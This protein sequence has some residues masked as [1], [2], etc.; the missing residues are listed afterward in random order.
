[1][2]SVT[3]LLHALPERFGERPALVEL[4]WSESSYRRE[5]LVSYAELSDA[6]WRFADALARHGLRPGDRVAVLLDNSAEMVAT[7][8]ACLL[9]GCLWVA[10]NAR[11]SPEEHR[12]I[13]ED[14]APAALV[15]SR[16]HR[17]ALP[18]GIAGASRLFVEV[19]PRGQEQG[20]GESLQC[21]SGLE[22]ERAGAAL[23][24]TDLLGGSEARL[25]FDLPGAEDPVRIRYTSGTAGRPKGAVLPRRCYDA[26]VEVVGELIGPLDPTDVL[27]QVAPMTHAAG[28]MWLPHAA[29]GATALLADRF[30]A[31]AFADL[32]Q[33]ERVTAAFLVPTMLLRFLERILDAAPLASLRTIV[34]GGASM[35]ADRLRSGLERLGPV[36]VQI[37]GMTESNWP[38]TALRRE[39]HVVRGSAEKVR[40]RLASCGRPT[41]IGRVRLVDGAG[42]DVARG[43]VGELLLRGR[44]TMSGYW[45]GL[46]NGIERASR[47]RVEAGEGLDAEGNGI[48]L[49]GKG[50]DAEGW[51]HSGD[52]AFEDGDGFLTIVDR[53]HDMIVSGGFNVY[54][55]EL[56]DALSTHPAVLESAVVG[57]PD[58]EWGETVHAVVVL[59]AGAQA[60]AADLAAHVAA[61]TA[62]YKKPRS[63]EFVEELPKNAAG[64]VLRRALREATGPRGSSDMA[65]GPERVA[66]SESPKS[67]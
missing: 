17:G 48:E 46:A 24:W 30:D 20:A 56:E 21:N 35:P 9:T 51:M 65:G 43:E 62:A 31:A 2:S 28:A 11:S 27:A 25:P 39:D 7:E 61:R 53:L 45:K 66:I 36:F 38:V 57:R 42:N 67:R 16:R 49:S 1:V 64:K 32:V 55:R 10:L 5:R 37:Y 60:S 34:Y 58:A 63:V 50:L 18:A 12:L 41:S 47:N 40:A 52:L 54:P 44:N 59:R 33:H 4:G 13:L 23:S 19:D 3:T 15:V 26:S 8:W 14:C 6:A 29:V 22:M